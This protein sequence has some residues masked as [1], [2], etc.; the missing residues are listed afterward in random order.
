MST[1]MWR[2]RPTILLPAS[3]PLVFSFW[4]FDRLAVDDASGWAR[5]ASH[6]LSVEHQ[7]DVVD[8]PKH[9]PTD[10]SAKPPIDRLP[11]RK[12]IRR[13]PPSPA[14]TGHAL[15]CV[16]FT[17]RKSTS[18][19]RPA[20]DARGRKGSIRAHSSSVKSLGYRLVFFSDLGH[21]ACA[22]LRSTSQAE[23]PP[24]TAFNDFSNGLSVRRQVAQRLSADVA[25][26]RPRSL[27][28]LVENPRNEAEFGSTWTRWPLTK[29]HPFRPIAA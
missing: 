15:D 24:Q 19:G 20:V 9:E 28:P 7:R 8:R 17:S 2:L 13:H 22:L 25:L 6:A 14:R 23:S 27:G 26:L 3:Y 21:S 29:A 11:R 16:R 1:A 5:F 12:I 10:K 4:S 18:I